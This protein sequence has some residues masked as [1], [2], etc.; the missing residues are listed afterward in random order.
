MLC[1]DLSAPLFVL[2]EEYLLVTEHGI[3]CNEPSYWT[4]EPNFMSRRIV[5]DENEK[6]GVNKDTSAVKKTPL[7]K[8]K[9]FAKAD[10]ENALD[11]L[12]GLKVPEDVHLENKSYKKLSH[13]PL[14]Y[15]Q[16]GF[17]LFCLYSHK[18]LWD[19]YTMKGTQQIPY[20]YA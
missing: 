12:N 14:V 18:L 9:S 3:R 13:V 8:V 15:A 11:K 19:C 6:H 1:I 20:P 4:I 16:V 17:S 5:F 7:L 2:E 10:A